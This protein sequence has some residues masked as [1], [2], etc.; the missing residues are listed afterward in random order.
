M[1]RIRTWMIV[2]ICSVVNAITFA[3]GPSYYRSGWVS[4][5]VLLAKQSECLKHG[6]DVPAPAGS[7][8]L[9]R[10]R[11]P[12][13]DVHGQ[14]TTL[15]GLLILP[16]S[17]PKGLV[18]YFHSTILDRALAPSRYTG[19]NGYLEPEYVM[20]AFATGGY[21]VLMP[22]ML[23]LGDNIGVHPYPC[24]DE[25]CRSGIDMIAPG[26]QVAKTLGIGIANHLFLTGYSE[27]G[28]VAMC[29]LRQIEKGK[30]FSA[31][32]AA[33]MSGP[34]DLS[35]ATARSLLKGGQ[36]PEGL[37]T[38]LFLLGYAAFSAYSN[39][40]SIDL[41]DYFA[42]SFASYLPYVFGLKLDETNVAK[43]FVGKAVQLGALTSIEKI[44]TQKFRNSITQSDSSNPIIA[45]MMK[46]D[47][48]NWT[49][50]TKMLLPYLK[51]DD[52]VIDT[53][54]HEAIDSMSLNG[55]GPDRLR[56][57]EMNDKTL[58]HSTAAPIAYSAARRFF[59][60]GFSGVWPKGEPAL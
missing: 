41:K 35:G 23:G 22:D 58:S 47:C 52:V 50:H 29:A 9:Y 49:P 53:N 17:A 14:P 59:D 18:L 42:P 37:G 5:D 19:F 39:L 12:S 43:K 54:T 3:S 34:Y 38:K 28:A 15:S 27:G 7:I 2:G 11:Y 6:L 45:E 48:F 20:M 57:F 1:T 36:S 16:K 25:N 26:R 30:E 55:V 40:R 4:K 51:G 8:Q 31:D 10:L 21:A 24:G 44:L 60:G 32:M 56:A 33:P 13:L 46:S